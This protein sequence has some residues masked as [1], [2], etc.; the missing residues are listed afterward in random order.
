[1]DIA[2]GFQLE[3]TFG[4]C[5]GID[6]VGRGALAGPVIVA[7]VYYP[8]K[9]C[10][11]MCEEKCTKYYTL[12]SKAR[13][14]KTLSKQKRKEL[15]KSFSVSLIYGIGAATAKEVDSVNVL[16]ATHNAIHR[17]MIAL[18]DNFN[19]LLA[20]Y[21]LPDIPL[22]NYAKIVMID[23]NRSPKIKGYDVQSIIR[24]DG[25]SFTIA[26]A[27][28]L[29]KVI[30]D[31]IMTELDTKFPQYNWS[32]NKGYGTTKHLDAIQEFGLCDQHRRS[33]VTKAMEKN[34]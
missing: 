32:Q 18:E 12:L 23:G 2:T 30:R 22:S 31:N 14:S 20:I 1:M 29:A 27:S 4:T 28:I 9:R 8:D 24:G 15:F 6:E 19:T 10:P 5:I 26:A 33:F 11:L 17:A 13:D 25:K 7:A 34:S 21:K 16:S 3:N